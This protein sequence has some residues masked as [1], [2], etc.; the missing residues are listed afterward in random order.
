[1]KEKF[2]VQFLNEDGSIKQTKNYKTLRQLEPIL[3]IEYH[4]VRSL[5]LHSTKNT[6]LHPFL[7]SI[8]QKVKI[9]DNP[10]LHKPISFDLI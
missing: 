7:K 3:N 10:D 9:I 5:Y 1:M 8:S 2:Q 4:Q 6:K